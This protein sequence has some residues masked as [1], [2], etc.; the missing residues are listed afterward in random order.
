MT[1]LRCKLFGHTPDKETIK[2]S[3]GT[4]I[5]VCKRCGAPIEK[6]SHWMD[7]GILDAAALIGRIEAVTKEA[8][9]NHSRLTVDRE[10]LLDTVEF[11]A[12]KANYHL[13]SNWAVQRELGQRAR[14]ALT[15]IGR[16]ARKALEEE[17]DG[18][19]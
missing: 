3:W 5:A 1:N 8:R 15:Y 11:Y 16:R 13:A 14:D 19:H 17:N 9:R 18:G 7:W 4:T 6:R 10:L 12:D 2:G